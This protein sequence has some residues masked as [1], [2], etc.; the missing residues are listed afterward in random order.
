MSTNGG[1]GGGNVDAGRL[2][3]LVDRYRRASGSTAGDRA[4]K[5]QLLDELQEAVGLSGKMVTE[6]DVLRRAEQ[7]LRGR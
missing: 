2:A 6:A 4:A 1:G 5:D 3:S 7:V